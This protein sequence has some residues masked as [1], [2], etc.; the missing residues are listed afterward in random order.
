M[1]GYNTDEAESLTEDSAAT[2]PEARW[3]PPPPK[4]PSD[5]QLNGTAP[6]FSLRKQ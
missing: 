2:A 1:K 5:G 4:A 3:E 6:G